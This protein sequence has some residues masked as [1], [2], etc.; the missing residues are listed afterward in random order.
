MVTRRQ[1][2]EIETMANRVILADLP[3]SANQKNFGDL[4]EAIAAGEIMA[5]FGEKYG[6]VVRVVH[7]NEN[8]R[9]YSQELCGGTHVQNTAQIGALHIISEGSAAAGVRRIE[10]V[11]GKAAQNLTQQRLH[12]LEQTAAL[13][14]VSPEGVYHRIKSLMTQLQDSDKKIR[15]LQR[16]LARLEFESLLNKAYEVKGVKVISLKVDAPDVAMLREMSDWFRD[17][18]GSGVVILGTVIAGKPNLIVT[19]TQDLVE[20]GINAGDLVK[21]AAHII[22]GSG[23]GRPAMAQAGGKDPSRLDEALA[24]ASSLV[25]A[26][27]A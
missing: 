4:R 23:G 20:R 9:A 19:V 22:G 1:L 12:D 11:T 6:E 17:Q 27:L 15:E 2:D 26:A 10:A 7:I 24:K 18:F 8:G 14:G 16:K 5:L 3:V 13:L 21:P 25:S